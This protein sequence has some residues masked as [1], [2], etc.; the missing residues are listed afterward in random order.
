MSNSH[1]YFMCDQA[2]HRVRRLMG[3]RLLAQDIIQAT[4]LYRPILLVA[5]G[6][7]T[8]VNIMLVVP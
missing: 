5:L 8:V 6:V 1:N 3:R 7:L 4:S 2:G